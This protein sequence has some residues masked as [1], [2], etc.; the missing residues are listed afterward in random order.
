[1]HASNENP[2]HPQK[3]SLKSPSGTTIYLDKLVLQG[4]GADS[5]DD[6]DVLSSDASLNKDGRLLPDPRAG[7]SFQHSQRV[8]QTVNA[9]SQWSPTRSTAK[10][11][12]CS[13]NNASCA[14]H[15]DS[16]SCDQDAHHDLPSCA[17]DSSAVAPYVATSSYQISCS[18]CISTDWGHIHSNGVSEISI[19]IRQCQ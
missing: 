1:M 7:K 14:V 10:N 15:R 6:L 9:W 3:G 13:A 18:L 8:N 16:T 17:L 19:S 2:H 4:G 11:S 12:T 5:Q